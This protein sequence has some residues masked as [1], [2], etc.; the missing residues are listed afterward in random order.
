MLNLHDAGRKV[1]SSVVYV[2]FEKI[3]VLLH[4]CRTFKLV[5][6]ANTV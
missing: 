4:D 3:P 6:V 2:F 5:C 1:V